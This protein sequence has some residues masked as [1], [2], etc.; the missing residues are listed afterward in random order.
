MVKKTIEYAEAR[1]WTACKVTLSDG[2]RLK[3]FLNQTK[4]FFV[5]FTRKPKSE[6]ELE[7][8]RL[9]EIGRHGFSVH[10]VSNVKKGRNVVDWETDFT[11]C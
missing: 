6:S 9:H 2:T 7:Q 11:T 1:G 5:W 10:I 8:T 3:M 4:I